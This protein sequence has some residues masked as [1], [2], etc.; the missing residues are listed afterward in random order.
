MNND[1]L[2]KNREKCQQDPRKRKVTKERLQEEALELQSSWTQDG[3]KHIVTFVMTIISL[4]FLVV[5]FTS[6]FFCNSK[7]TLQVANSTA[8][9]E[10][11]LEIFCQQYFSLPYSTMVGIPLKYENWTLQ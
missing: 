2:R 8:K 7:T 1:F 6:D 4:L 5:C 9:R 3:F 11:L 10:Y